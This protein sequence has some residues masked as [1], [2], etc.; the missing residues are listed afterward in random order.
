MIGC[1]T[2]DAAH[3]NRVIQRLFIT[4]IATA[5]TTATVT[6]KREGA[7]TSGELEPGRR[8]I[9]GTLVGLP[10]ELNHLIL[11]QAGQA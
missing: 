10:L 2:G 5:K 11:A 1:A 9:A 8:D 3:S 4:T 6:W 7:R